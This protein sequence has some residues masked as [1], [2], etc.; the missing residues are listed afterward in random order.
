[1]D[2]R[3]P[4]YRSYLLRLWWA[5]DE[6]MVI[7]RIYVENPLTGKRRGFSDLKELNAFLREE[8]GLDEETRCEDKKADIL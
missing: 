2:E 1:M 7:L 3:Q 6:D 8:V 5:S 4:D